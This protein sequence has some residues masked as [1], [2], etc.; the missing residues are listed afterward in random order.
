MKKLILFLTFLILNYSLL[1]ASVRYV[2]HSGSNTPPYLTWETAADSIMGA[3]NISSFGDTIYVANGVYEE[4]VVMIPGLSLIGAGMDSCVIDT[5]TLVNSTGFVCVEV[6]D[7]CLLQGFHILAYNNT[8]MAKGISGGGGSSSMVTLNKVSNAKYGAFIDRTFYPLADIT[9]YENI[10]ENV[11]TGVELFNSSSLVRGNTIYTDLQWRS[12]NIGAYDYFYTPHIDSNYIVAGDEGISMVF[13]TKATISNNKIFLIGNALD[14][15]FGGNPDTC[16]IYNNLVVAGNALYGIG[17]AVDP[18][19]N[20]NNILIGNFTGINVRDYNVI[21]NNL[22]FNSDK[23]IVATPGENPVIKYNNSW[24]NTVNY[25]GFTPDSTNLSV[26]P[27]VVNTDT[28]QGELDFHLQM[29]SPLI[30]KG[31]PEILDKDGTRSDIGLYGGPFG[32]RYNYQDLPPRA[33][34]NLSATVDSNYIFL[35]WDRNTEADFNHYNLYSDTTENFNLDTTTFVA[36]IEDTFYLQIRPEAINNLYLKA[37]CRR[38]P[39]ECV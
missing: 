15:I 23:G 4:Q 2:S 21:K 16:W 32:E 36:S 13:G 26:D 35:K 3:I 27:M 25:S 37:Y 39:G 17:N 22:T 7:S 6:A 29:F 24:N 9:V 18:G 34:V 31:D 19:F 33:P 1:F 8:E 38:Q 12:I 11:R 10:F 5:R 30:N 14:G 20:Y 28:S